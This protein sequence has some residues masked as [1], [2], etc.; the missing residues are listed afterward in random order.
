MREVAIIGT[1]PAGHTAAIYTA[2]ALLK[3][4]VFSGMQPGGQLTTTSEIENFPGFPEAI[5]GMQLMERMEQ[6]ALR[7]GTELRPGCQVVR[8][9]VCPGG[10]R[11]TWDDLY[12]G[13]SASEEFRAVIVA[14]GASARYPGL[15]GEAEFLD[16]SGRK[17]GLSAC[18]TCDGALYKGLAV[19][20][21]GGGDTACEEALFLTRYASRVHLIHRRDALRASKVMAQRVLEHPNI[22]PHWFREPAAYHTDARG[23]IEALTL[24]DPRTNTEERL[25]VQG[26]FMAIGHQPN[27][28]FLKDLPVRCDEAGY[29]EVVEGCKTSVPGLFAAGDVRDHHYRQAVTAAGMGCMAALEAERFLA[30]QSAW[31]V[32]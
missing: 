1:G 30:G 20:V 28:A 27:T 9:E 5:S 14:T 23:R 16:G 17:G 26:V 24:R 12:Q 29:L 7:F 2:R 6:Q 8:V 4:V 21:V 25:A 10:L 13:L 3:P 15:P 31:P 32:G 18:A 22:E 19:A 11:L